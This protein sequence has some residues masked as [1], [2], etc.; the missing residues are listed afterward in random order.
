M[1]SKVGLAKAIKVFYGRTTPLYFKN[2]SAGYYQDFQSVAPFIDSILDI[3]LSHGLIYQIN[4]LGGKI[5]Q[6]ALAKR[7]CYPHRAFPFL[8]EIQSY[9]E[10]P[11]QAAHFVP[12]FTQVQEILAL[13][14]MTAQYVNYPSLLF[15]NPRLAYFGDNY[16]RL[17]ESKARF[18]PDDLFSSPQG[19]KPRS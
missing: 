19:I 5:N 14:G 3:T 8:S 16:P 11:E 7:S 13:H 4:T 6:E 12:Q 15:K 9:W 1:G 18:D 17:Q 10:R 2:A